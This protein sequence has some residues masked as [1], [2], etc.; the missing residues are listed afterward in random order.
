MKKF[1]QKLKNIFQNLELT[2]KAEA[3]QLTDDDWKSVAQAYNKDNPGHNF[4]DDVA[5]ALKEEN[6]AKEQASQQRAQ[7]LAISKTVLPE[8]SEPESQD[9]E[10]GKSEKPKADNTDPVAIVQKMASAIE[11]LAGGSAPDKPKDVVTPVLDINGPGT[12]KSHFLGIP[13][14]MFSLEKRWNKIS[15][16][17]SFAIQNP[18]PTA[19][20]F[21]SF[22][23]EY[24]TF[25]L[26]LAERYAYLKK[27]NLLDAK[28]LMAFGNDYSGLDPANLGDY[29]LI[30][31]QDALIARLITLYNVYDIF[32]RR[33]GVQ[34]REVMFSAFFDTV[35]QAWQQGEVFKGEMKLQPEL[36]YVDDAM[37]KLLFKPMKE[38]ERMYIGYLNT[39]GSDPMKWSIIEWQILNVMTQAISEQ[40]HRRIMGI[41][42]HPETG[43]PGHYLNSSTG[44]VYTLLR[45]AHEFKLKLH[46]DAAFT[47]YT[48]STFLETVQ[49]MLEQ[50]KLDITE[51]YTVPFGKLVVYLNDNH[52]LWWKQN[53]RAKY[54]K[55]ND[56]DKSSPDSMINKVPDIDTPIIWVPNLGNTPIILVQEPGNLQCVEYVPGEML[57]LQFEPAMETYKGWTV[58]KE[59]TS[60]SFVGL[61]FAT[62]ALMD[63][64]LSLI[65]I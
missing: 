15:A 61:Q 24:R 51:D 39:E 27:N 50:I 38:I 43:I 47:G 13:H 63:A 10:N 34:D 60:A 3:G 49:D 20:D 31:R 17:P 58:W 21:E 16:D 29:Y 4:D 64:N 42:V 5:S 56:F 52:K 40:N 19:E 33:Y 37:I 57:A 12:N 59:G 18:K 46:D 25:S 6:D 36:A 54:A 32:P 44:V 22:T 65:H 45:Y 11:K 48:S 62:K 41:Y 8:D 7:I 53:C 2:E 23:K 35:S 30:R 28:R 26:G 1:F 55:D 14:S 9:D